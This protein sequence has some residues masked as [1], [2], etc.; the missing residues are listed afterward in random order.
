MQLQESTDKFILV[1]NIHFHDA[2]RG[3]YID[4]KNMIFRL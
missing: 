4:E 2:P 3:K 1:H